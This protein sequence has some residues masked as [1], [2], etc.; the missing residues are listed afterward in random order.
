RAERGGDQAAVAAAVAA[1]ARCQVLRGEAVAARPLL[2]RA[3]ELHADEAP[4]RTIA[5]RVELAASE[6]L[7][8]LTREAIVA[9]ERAAELSVA[10]AYARG[11]GWARHALG[12]ARARAGDPR[13]GR[14]DPDAAPATPP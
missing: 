3:I 1:L 13:R 6:A 14:A 10:L 9:L 5:L 4:Q 12:R 11:E 8:G 2:A 7:L